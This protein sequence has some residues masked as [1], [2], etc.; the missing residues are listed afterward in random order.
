MVGAL[1]VIPACARTR[2]VARA[3]E[4]QAPAPSVVLAKTRL[5]NQTGTRC[6]V[7][8]TVVE[9]D[10]APRWWWGEPVVLTATSS[11]DYQLRAFAD[12]KA[13]V[14]GKRSV[15]VRVETLLGTRAETTQWYNVIGPMPV[16]IDLIRV[17]DDVAPACFAP[18]TI[19]PLAAELWPAP[20]SAAA[21][22]PA[23]Q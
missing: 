18:A 9:A 16:R 7:L 4:V 17:G 2:E 1:A 23:P 13:P 3:P 6:R 12:D 15:L 21:A 20:Q 22:E 11:E 14:A 5:T 10:A 19:E 8:M